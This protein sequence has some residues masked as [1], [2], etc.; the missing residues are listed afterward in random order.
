MSATRSRLE[1]R[2]GETESR[3]ARWSGA[4]AKF[5]A[6]SANKATGR[7]ILAVT[8]AVLFVGNVRGYARRIAE[9]I[10]YQARSLN[11]KATHL[12][13]KAVKKAGF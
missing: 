2:R 1:S 10:D 9:V 4:T 8:N 3:A 5:T 7:F 6:N 11:G 12:L 13:K